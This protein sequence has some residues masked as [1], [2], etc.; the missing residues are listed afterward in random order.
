VP[1]SRKNS[2]P[3]AER[4]ASRYENPIAS[5]EYILEILAQQGPLEFKS[6]VKALKLRGQEQRQAVQ[7]RLRAMQRDGQVLCNRAG[8]YGVAQKMD[9]I[10]G[11]VEAHRDGYGFLLREGEDDIFL[12]PAAMRQIF[13]GDEVLVQ[14]VGENRRG[15]PEGKIVE[16]LA[17]NT[18]RVV[19][20]LHQNTSECY[21]VPDNPRISHDILLDK[22]ALGGAKNGDYVIIEITEYP[23]RHSRARGVVVQVLGEP[24]APG[25]EIDIATHRY[26]LPHEWPASCLSQAAE[27]GDQPAESDKQHRVDLR[28]LPLVTIDGEDA[29]DFDDA[30]YC[31][32]HKDGSYSLWVAIADVS[33]YVPVGSA[34]D[35]EAGLRGTSV[36]FPGRVIPMLPEALSNG[37]C[38][39]NPEVDRLCMVCEMQ[40]GA[41]GELADYQ[42]Y[43][44]VMHSHARLTYNEVAEVLGLLDKPARE[45]LAQ[46]LNNLMPQLTQLYSLFNLLTTVRAKRGAIEFES[47]ETKIIFDE[48]RKIDAIVPVS[49]NHAHRIIEECMLCANVATASFLAQHKIDALF[50]V[51]EGPK[52]EKLKNLRV[53]LGELGLDLAGGD[54]PTPKNYQQLMQQIAQRSDA[55]LI[56]IMLLRSLSQ[57]VYSNENNGH[58]G[59]AYSAYTH[60]TSPIRRYP[61]LLVH[62]AIKHV[63]H[64]KKSSKQVRRVDGAPVLAKK[65]I[66]PYQTSDM[67]AA[68]LHCSMT[69][70]R[71]DDATRDV[72]AWLKCEYLL[73]H[74]GETFDGVIAGVTGFGMFVE[75]SELYIE[76]LVHI[77]GLGQDYFHFDA[78]TQRL[79]GERSRRVYRMGDAVTVVVAGVDMD[80]RKVDLVLEGQPGKRDAS[81]KKADKPRNPRQ[82]TSGKKITASKAKSSKAKSSKGKPGKG[83]SG[84]R[85]QSPSQSTD[86]KA[87]PKATTAPANKKPNKKKGRRKKT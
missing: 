6:V 11:K 73:E 46:R 17:R 77:S 80:Q 9:L 87:K 55:H 58:F 50:R 43:E 30:V 44:A 74:V 20:R 82:K 70:R 81:A 76:G 40:I 27:L 4:E 25:L 29:R 28:H 14:Q 39:L 59:L 18:H 69:E 85:K 3:H 26:E 67:V 41:D 33:H 56:Q 51:H 61:D 22:N 72:I 65:L 71:A 54:K 10:G 66:Y 48:Q 75:L 79:V 15:Q 19:G 78:A 34:L 63:I 68:G 62:R 16:I 2:D 21:V 36:Y 24:M 37:L 38:S 31:E 83:K 42:F 1:K 64:S 53:Y 12:G 52:A 86:K 60:F 32:Q 5:R 7:A 49:R 47:V 57:A 23:A 8:E 13:H 84:K 35:T 45:G